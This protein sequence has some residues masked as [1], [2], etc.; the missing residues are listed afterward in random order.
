[1][2]LKETR[3]NTTSLL[4]SSTKSALL[5]YL[6]LFMYAKRHMVMVKVFFGFFLYFLIGILD[7]FIQT[8]TCWSYVWPE[9]LRDSS[10]GWFPEERRKQSSTA[11]SCSSYWPACMWHNPTYKMSSGPR[12]C[13]SL[14]GLE[15]IKKNSGIWFQRKHPAGNTLQPWHL[16]ICRLRLQVNIWVT[17]DDRD[18]WQ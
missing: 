7:N 5:N 13:R 15:N 4:P 17:S 18:G 12:G 14:M 3:I 2:I 1:M 11:S 16:W 6:K 10:R 9:T 8:G